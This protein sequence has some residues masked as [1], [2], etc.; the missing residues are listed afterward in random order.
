MDRRHFMKTMARAGRWALLAAL[1]PVAAY[2][3]AGSRM[4]GRNREA[5]ERTR[6][7]SL[8][9]IARDKLHHAPGG[10]A[11]PF[12]QDDSGNF[13]QVMRW[14]LFS[15]NRFKTFYR[16]EEVRPVRVDW[17]AVRR[18]QG[19]SLTFIKHAC[20]MIQDQGRRLLVDP[21]F[22]GI[23][24]LVKDFS[25]LDFDPAD[26]PPPDY[27]LLTHGH[28]DHIDLP[29]LAKLGPRTRLISPLGYDGVFDGLAVKDRTCLDWFESYASDGLEMTLLPCNHWTMRNPLQGP[30][31]ALWGSYLV[32]TRSGPTVFVSGDAAW[33]D[34]YRELG[35]LYD[36]DLAVFNLGAYE[37]RW[38]MKKSHMNPEEVVRSFRDLRAARLMIVHWGTFRLGDEPVHFPPRDLRQAMI[39][40]GLEDR[41][42]HLDHGRTLFFEDLP[43]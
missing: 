5:F 38:F 20:L 37:P 10:F 31:R 21:I 13:G 7:L 42:V 41:L 9:E 15:P 28:F 24:R 16:E 14:K 43:S 27:V 6:G 32:K 26:A 35:A 8:R 4:R 11:N 34:G 39:Q 36:I 33:F 29:T 23:S 40:A 22:G 1:F 12:T 2:Q 19:L 30:N 17:E 3:C 18:H 25:P